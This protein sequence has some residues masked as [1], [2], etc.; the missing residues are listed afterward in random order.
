MKVKP[1]GEIEAFLLPYAKEVGVEIVEVQWNLREPSLTVYID[2]EGGVD[3][4]LCEKF[5]RAI[6]AP[7]DELD[8]S[9]GTP[10]TLNCSSPGLD[11]PFRSE[12]DFLRHIGEQIEV[13]LYAA[14]EGKKEWVGELIGFEDGFFRIRTESGE[15]IF[16]LEKTAK[17]CL[18]IEV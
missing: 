8:P 16:S 3:L 2:A 14:E 11:R 6:D 9:F 13:H 7:L 10:Y 1:I 12:R 15:K 17:V 5:H 18:Y 4:I